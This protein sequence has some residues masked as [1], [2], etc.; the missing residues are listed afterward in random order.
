MNL[1]MLP[2]VGNRYA[3]NVC[4]WMTNDFDDCNNMFI[5]I[6]FEIIFSSDVI[7]GVAVIMFAGADIFIYFT[8]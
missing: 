7:S 2:A 4:Y 8:T 1:D 5:G 3:G 6:I